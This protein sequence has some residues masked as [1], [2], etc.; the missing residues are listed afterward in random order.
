[1]EISRRQ[2]RLTFVFVVLAA[3][4]S[5]STPT[6]AVAPPLPPPPTWVLAWSDEFDGAAGSSFDA[7]KWAP[8]LG[9]DG[10]GNQEREFYT[11]RPENIAQDG[12][13]HLVITARAEPAT[14]TLSCWYGTCHYTSARIRTKGLFSQTYGRFEARLKIPRGQ[15]LWPAFWMLGDNITTVGWPKSGEIDIMENIGREP[16]IVHGTMHGP[17]YSGAGGIGAPYTLATGTFADDFH[18]Y[19]V[20]WMPGLITWFVDDTKYFQAAPEHLPSSG[21][22]VFD[23]PFYLLLNVAVGG[24]WPNDPDATTTFPQAMVVDYVRVYKAKS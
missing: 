24:G 15:G 9:G 10:W 18:T 7:A 21:T 13:G 16:S 11:T 19:A 4:A 20:E 23:H 22:W 2:S 14:T 17:G 6:G 5:S 3:C 1:M 8:E 12:S